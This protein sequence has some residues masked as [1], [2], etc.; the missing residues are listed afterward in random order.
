MHTQTSKPPTS[1]YKRLPEL[2]AAT[3]NKPE[4]IGSLFLCG[5]C[6]MAAVGTFIGIAWFWM[7]YENHSHQEAKKRTYM[8]LAFFCALGFGLV[9]LYSSMQLTRRLF[10]RIHQEAS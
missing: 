10:A 3:V 7:A 9:T 8:A 2:E 5:R 4:A 1:S 6:M